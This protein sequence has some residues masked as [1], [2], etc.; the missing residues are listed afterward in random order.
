[1]TLRWKDNGPLVVH[2]GDYGWVLS[3]LPRPVLSYINPR[4]GHRTS[5]H[6][7]DLLAGWRWVHRERRCHS[8]RDAYSATDYGTLT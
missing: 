4:T 5:Y 1:M 3:F 7:W 8:Q 6:G 2:T